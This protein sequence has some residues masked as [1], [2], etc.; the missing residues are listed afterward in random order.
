MGSA[1]MHGLLAVIFLFGSAF[2][3]SKKKEDSL[4]VI[5]FLP[6]K[7]VDQ[8]LY[9]GGNPLVQPQP[10]PPPALKPI[11]PEVKPLPVPV[12]PQPPPKV[13]KPPEQ[14]K[15]KEATKPKEDIE[16][17]YESKEPGLTKT[18]KQQTNNIA[19]RISLT[20]VKRPNV[21]RAALRAEKEAREQA[22][23]DARAYAQ[24]QKQVANAARAAGRISSQ[25]GSQLSANTGS[26]EAPGPGGYAFANY[27]QWVQ[28]VYDMAWVSDDLE[29]DGSM[30]KAKVTIAR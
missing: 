9:G 30:V 23:A 19:D 11:V 16:P 8:M 26:V 3:T 20:V 2:F 4:P 28:S 27:G 25:L 21:D 24:Y 17:K 1:A 5:N 6:D 22:E 29:D 18:K 7:L 15:P 14:V 12:A 13:V 10:L